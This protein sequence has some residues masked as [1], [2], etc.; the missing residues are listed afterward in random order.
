MG[1][2]LLQVAREISGNFTQPTQWSPN[3]ENGTAL[4]NATVPNT[5]VGPPAGSNSSGSKNSTATQATVDWALVPAAWY[6]GI[7]IL[8]MTLV[9]V[10]MSGLWFLRRRRQAGAAPASPPPP[11]QVAQLKPYEGMLV[12]HPDESLQLAAKLPEAPS[13][14]AGRDG[15]EADACPAG[16]A[17]VGHVAAAPAGG[18]IINRGD[19]AAGESYSARPSSAQHGG[20]H[21]AATRTP[22]A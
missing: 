11:P 8:A 21:G 3:A 15:A 7:G 4:G 9:A 22:P 6:I 14:S 16:V 17:G 20:L 12:M 19:S 2:Y 13:S 5:F 10:C 18:G 1:R